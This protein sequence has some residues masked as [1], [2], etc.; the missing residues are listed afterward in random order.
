MNMEYGMN[1]TVISKAEFKFDAFIYLDIYE[2]NSVV[3]FAVIIR[4]PVRG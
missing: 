2:C 4:M 1:S 3:Q